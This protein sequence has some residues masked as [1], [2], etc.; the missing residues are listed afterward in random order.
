MA[1]VD[2]LS[3]GESDVDSEEVITLGTTSDRTI[4]RGSIV[5]AGS[6]IDATA[7]ELCV[8]NYIKHVQPSFPIIHPH[9]LQNKDSIV[10]RAAGA[11]GS[12]CL[13][14]QK[15]RDESESYFDYV[16][17][18]VQSHFQDETSQSSSTDLSY[19]QA[20]IL[21]QYGS[22]L[23]GEDLY[24]VDV[25]RFHSTIVAHAAELHLHE[26]QQSQFCE[27]AAERVFWVEWIRKEEIIRSIVALFILD[28]ELS[29][30]HNHKPLLD[31]NLLKKPRASSDNLFSATS[32]EE[33]VQNKSDTTTTRSQLNVYSDIDSII[34]ATCEARLNKTLDDRRIA[35]FEARLTTLYAADLQRTPGLKDE[36]LYLRI[37][38]HTAYLSLSC[39]FQILKRSFI[40]NRIRLPDNDQQYVSDWASDWAAQ[41][42]V[43]HAICIRNLIMSCSA[44]FEPPL[45]VTRA[46]YLGAICTFIF[47]EYGETSLLE[48]E[49]LY[50]S[51]LS[52]CQQEPSLL[53]REFD[54]DADNGRPLPAAYNDTLQSMV[55][56]LHR[57]GC[58]PLGEILASGL[59]EVI[60]AAPQSSLPKS[61]APYL[62]PP[63][64]ISNNKGKRKLHEMLTDL[65]D[66]ALPRTEND[67]LTTPEIRE[68]SDLE[69]RTPEAER[70]RHL[71]ACVSCHDDEQLCVPVWGQKCVRCRQLSLRCS[72][73]ERPRIYRLPTGVR[74][75]AQESNP[76]CR[77]CVELGR[78][79]YRSLG[80]EV[81]C[82]ECYFENKYCYS[83][84]VGVQQLYNHITKKHH[85][86]QDGAI[87][88]L[89]ANL[90]GDEA[91][92]EYTMD[93]DTIVVQHSSPMQTDLA[94]M[95]SK[96]RLKNG[97]QAQYIGAGN[98]SASNAATATA[99]S[100]VQASPAPTKLSVNAQ[101]DDPLIVWADW[102]PKVPTKPG[103]ESRPCRRV[104]RN[105]QTSLTS[106]TVRSMV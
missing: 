50:C 76:R 72:R 48:A 44:A 1:D 80:N 18:E 13:T 100:R 98:L 99:G 2:I 70:L 12:L 29:I 92:N 8:R 61:L 62:A 21:L 97:A 54:L 69:E 60:N 86:D 37:L 55:D 94:G 15:L 52:L 96:K 90:S 83:S 31:H 65:D 71:P 27:V 24:L 88:G 43:L 10:Y 104:C 106:N 33:W 79:C 42:C 6:G 51:E 64:S 67:Q 4:A 36:N 85:G 63:D 22:L 11:V 102:L 47:L 39:S 9:S 7:I 101:S 23:S 105:S 59:Q 82:D 56:M 57:S 45:Y 84:L 35:R 68:E 16:Q 14:S 87:V 38:W 3:I 103:A 89:D 46:L 40:A 20:A 58:W 41:R 73:M 53:L 74:K 95:R 17:Q 78:Q 81:A 75:A 91:D 28:A 19:V 93:R 34:A 26:V 77:R 49:V 5:C 25:V 66:P 30:I 32:E